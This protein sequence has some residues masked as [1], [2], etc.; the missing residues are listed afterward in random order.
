MDIMELYENAKK[1]AKQA[2][3]AG[4]GITYQRIRV[5]VPFWVIG[6]FSVVNPSIIHT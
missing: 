1:V 5:T 6:L 3:Y 4:M 2:F